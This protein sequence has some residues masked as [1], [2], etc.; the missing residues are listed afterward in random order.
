M[1]GRFPIPP[2]CPRV[3]CVASTQ[4]PLVALD[5][6]AAD[7]GGPRLAE[8]VDPQGSPQD[9]LVEITIRE[10]VRPDGPPLGVGVEGLGQV[11]QDQAA[12]VAVV[13]RGWPE[14]IAGPLDDEVPEGDLQLRPRRAA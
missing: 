5:A 14:G 7:L 1:P 4:L 9:D 8:R 6:E 2:I 13:D 3:L 11:L 12:D 10:A